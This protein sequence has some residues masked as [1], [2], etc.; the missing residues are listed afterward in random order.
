MRDQRD[1]WEAATVQG[2]ALFLALINLTAH[3][4]PAAP[5][6]WPADPSPDDCSG[7]AVGESRAER[8]SSGNQKPSQTAWGHLQTPE[9]V[10]P[11]NQL[12][13]CSLYC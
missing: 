3:R 10:C 1:I 13:A 2:S 9:P 5:G 7:G 6:P 4:C 11:I 12:G 8:T